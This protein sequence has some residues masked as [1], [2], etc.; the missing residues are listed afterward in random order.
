MYFAI[1]KRCKKN[2]ELLIT[3]LGGTDLLACLSNVVF[4]WAEYTQSNDTEYR[5]G[6]SMDAL[7][8][9]PFNKLII[10]LSFTT[11][12]LCQLSKYG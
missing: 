7:G 2:Y 11:H 9:F 3:P 10:M 8:S 5:I 12:V 4:G 1:I 6:Q